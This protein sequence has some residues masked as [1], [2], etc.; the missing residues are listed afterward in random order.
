M[1]LCYTLL[2]DTM[3][4]VTK[5]MT[6][7]EIFKLKE[8]LNGMILE[9][10]RPEYTYYR[11]KLEDC[12]ITAY[13]SGKVVF[14][15]KDLSWLEEEKPSQNEEIYPMAGS[16]EVGTG[17]YFGP[18]VVAACI[19]EQKDVQM[20][21]KLGIH[22]SKQV[23]DDKIRALAPSIKK[24][25]PHTILVVSPEKYNQVHGNHNMVDIKC[26]LHNQAYLN[27]Q[28][29][30]Y[31]LPD[32]IIIDQFV[33][34]KSY[35]RYLSKE[36]EVVKGIHFE[37]KAENKYLA[38]ACASI[39]ARDTFLEYWDKMEE[40]YDFTFEKGAGEKVDLCAKVFV[41]QFGFDTLEKVAKLH[42]KNTEKIK[43]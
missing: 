17:D 25:C 16:D 26:L 33:S 4:S 5:K 43:E 9:S 30:G 10:S 28:K 32:W 37:T 14:Q 41:D 29:K 20:L 35:Y 15:G 7:D 1:E 12:T 11:L 2:G 40:S 27:L 18:I 21:K 19:V 34:E 6:K 38:V 22:D 31:V 23:T 42:F 24:V 36:K 13:T 8:S 3:A 39:L